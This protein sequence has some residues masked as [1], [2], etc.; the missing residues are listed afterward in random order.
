MSFVLVH[1]DEC[2]LRHHTVTSIPVGLQAYT[3][4]ATL[5]SCTP[6]RLDVQQ[7]AKLFVQELQ[8]TNTQSQEE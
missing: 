8:L 6:Q 1:E 7:L 2:Q 5:C 3:D 4:V